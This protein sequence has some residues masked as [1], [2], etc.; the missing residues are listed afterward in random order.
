M[1][2]ENRDLIY[3]KDYEIDYRSGRILLRQ[4]LS[5]VSASET[6]ISNDILDGNPVY[7][8]VDYEFESFRQFED[9]TAGLRGFTHFLGDHLRL[10]ATAV[11]VKPPGGPESE[12]DLRG[13]D[14][15]IRFGRNTK[16]TAEYAE[17]KHEQV[18]QATSFDGGLSFTGGGSRP[19]RRPREKAYLIKAE[20][21]PIK[22]LEVSG[23]L[24]HVSPGF[25]VDRI[26]D[27]NEEG[28][29]KYGIQSKLKIHPSFY[30][31]ARHD[32][33][34]VSSQLRPLTEKGIFSE[35]ERVRTTVGQAVFDHGKWNV[36]GEY[37][38]QRLDIPLDNRIESF[39]SEKPFGNSFGLKIAHRVLDWL[40]PYAKGQ[41]TFS[42]KRN[43]QIG[44][45]LE[46]RA[47]DKVKVYFEEMI[48]GIGDATVL[49]VNIQQDENTSSYAT[50]RAR[51]VGMGERRVSTTVGS[52][53][54]LSERSRIYTE[55]EY[56]AYPG[57][58]PRSLMPTFLGEPLT[59]GVWSSDIYGY[60]TRFVDRWDLGLRFERRH[61]D[62]TDFSSLRNLGTAGLVRSNSWNT[63]AASVGYN[64]QKQLKF[65]DSLELRLDHEEPEIRQWLT[66]NRLDWKIN[67]DL[68]FLGRLNFGTSRFFGIDFQDTHRDEAPNRFIEFSTG[69]AYRPVA[70]DRLNWLLKYTYLDEI[71][72]EAQFQSGDSGVVPID[73]R[74]HTFAIEGGYDLTSWLQVIEKFA[75][76]ASSLH[77]LIDD[78]IWV[79]TYLWVHRFN[80]HITRKWD[81]AAEYRMLFQGRE[82]DSVL[83]GPL[84]ELDREIFDYVRVGIGYN[85]TDFD[86]DLRKVNDFRR[87]G[88]FVRLTGKV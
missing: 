43:Y 46:I 14:A 45:G 7:L 58:M 56:S 12:Y 85:F 27:L 84:V 39:F 53:H 70:S 20:S 55:R 19:I 79:N 2:L 77:A 31:L 73:E 18:K 15:L 80:F 11:E 59:P 60:E 51:D 5:S 75:F 23:Y 69:L 40:T 82:A 8:I 26:Y 68:S 9:K 74:S 3:G 13:V 21:K 34:E 42:G 17:A 4:P 48:G 63:L 50:M 81:F 1:V 38:N 49:G 28:L 78:R 10:G 29:R 24:Q 72:N 54:Q 47:N 65:E 32:S 35:L 86:D 57:S 62:T 25:N 64:D 76:R 30:L 36:I 52:S 71:A 87:N 41:M 37:M 83:H 61:L 6:I 88:L 22:P 16:I 33:V 67:Q 44:G 66:Q